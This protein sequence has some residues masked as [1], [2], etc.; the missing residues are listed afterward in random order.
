[1][2]DEER[3]S[4]TWQVCLTEEDYWVAG[5]KI[6]NPKY[7][8]GLLVHEISKINKEDEV[9]NLLELGFKKCLHKIPNV[10]RE[11][12]AE[13]IFHH[14]KAN[15][16]DIPNLVFS[17]ITPQ[18]IQWINRWVNP[19]SPIMKKAL[20]NSKL[21]GY[22]EGNIEILRECIPQCEKVK[23]VADIARLMVKYLPEI[24]SR[25]RKDLCEELNNI[26]FKIKYDAWKKALAN[27]EIEAKEE[28]KSARIKEA[29]NK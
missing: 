27:A 10:S 20:C 22:F 17:P 13:H 28:A 5:D 18:Q 15:K 23:S 1:M 24:P 6:L 11:M 26:G 3:K 2:T 16:L 25:G 7:N 21:R 14:I 9:F 12:F 19:D 29:A 8:Y 4:A